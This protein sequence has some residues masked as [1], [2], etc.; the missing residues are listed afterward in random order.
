MNPWTLP[1]DLANAID[2]LADTLH[3]RSRGKLSP[4]LTGILFAQG[5][6]TVTSWLRAVNV[7][8]DFPPYYYFLAVLG[9]QAQRVAAALLG[10]LVQRLAPVGPWLFALDD[11]PTKRYGPKVEGA[12]IHHNPTP[13][14]TDQKFLYGHVWVTLA[15]VVRHPLWGTLALPLLAAMYVRQ[16]DV[17]TIKPRYRWTFQTKL[18]LAAGL[19]LW[20]TTWLNR[21]GRPVWIVA[22]GAYAKRP[23]IRAIRQA[24]MV[25]ISRLRHDAALWSLPPVVPAG[26]RKRGQPRKYGTQRFHLAKRAGQRRGWRTISVV[27][28]G[29]PVT[30]TYKTFLATYRPAGGTIRVVLVREDDG[31]W[32]AF[33]STDPELTV[34]A[35]L[36]A[37]SDRA[38]LEQTFKDVKEVEGAGQQQVRNLLAN[39]GAWNVNLWVHALVEWWAWD[40]PARRI[41]DRRSRPWDDPERRPS[42]ADRRKAL[43]RQSIAEE[44]SRV[45]L[46]QQL[47][48]RIRQL[49]QRLVQWVA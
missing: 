41:R 8:T 33:F 5:R 43:Q 46:R 24:E 3:Q 12:G 20:L 26:R 44:F 11:S 35:I 4:L 25:L 6:R 27:Q 7:G 18:E 36:E 34:A 16:K 1:T 32:L 38:A 31:H 30:K 49:L 19:L 14:P 47:P 40:Q 45:Q 13:G 37:V 39:I 9:R 22:D 42:H 28:Y 10:L 29:R 15:W 17:P 21:Q 23:L 2:R 48:R